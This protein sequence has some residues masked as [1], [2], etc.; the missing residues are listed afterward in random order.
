MYLGTGGL[1][2]LSKGENPNEIEA[3]YIKH[4]ASLRGTYG[5]VWLSK[6]ENHDETDTMYMYNKHSVS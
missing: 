6:V 5:L 1:V 2:W 4:S 3:M